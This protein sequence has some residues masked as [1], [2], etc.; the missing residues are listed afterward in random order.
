MWQVSDFFD[1][2]RVDTFEAIF[3]LMDIDGGNRLDLNEVPQI[4][5]AWDFSLL[6]QA[7]AS[8]HCKA[9]RVLSA[10]LSFLILCCPPSV[11]VSFVHVSVCAR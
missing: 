4:H 3:K 5:Q 1:D 9:V 7:C 6:R 2:D 8:K 10:S 11:S